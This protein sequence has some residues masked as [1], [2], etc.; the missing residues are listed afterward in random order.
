VIEALTVVL[1]LTLLAIAGL[2]L[3]WGLG[4]FWRGY[5]HDSLVG[6][7]VGL[8]PGNPLP[9][10]WACLIVV[11]CLMVPVVAAT[12]IT[13]NL[14]SARPRFLAWIPSTALWAYVVVFFGR[15]LATYSW[16]LDNTNG[17]AFYG[18]NRTFYAPLCLALGI[19]LAIVGISRP[20][21]ALAQG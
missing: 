5:D 18:L 15:G 16:V 17:T 4:V 20:R 9:P 11:A 14:V 1:S 12:M 8:G 3:Y 6:M 13:L 2:H 10:L 21:R 19:G 7:V